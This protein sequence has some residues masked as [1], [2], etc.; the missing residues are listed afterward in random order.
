MKY[1]PE[2]KLMYDTK[3]RAHYL[4]TCFTAPE[5]IACNVMH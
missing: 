3:T 4:H 2:T 5:C 1:E